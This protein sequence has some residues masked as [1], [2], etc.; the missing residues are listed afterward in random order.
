MATDE[1]GFLLERV[2][3][4][5]MKEVWGIL[6][7]RV[8]SHITFGLISICVCFQVVREQ[9]WLNEILLSCNWTTGGSQQAEENIQD[10]SVATEN[11][12]QAVLSG[13]FS[14]LFLGHEMG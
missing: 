11:D 2:P 14:I 10:D 3:V 5:S 6:E 1:P 8:F 7:V 13:D 9:C 12:L 4:H